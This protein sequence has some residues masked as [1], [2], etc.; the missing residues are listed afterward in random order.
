MSIVSKRFLS[1]LL[2]MFIIFIILF[3]IKQ[4]LPVNNYEIELNNLNELYVEKKIDSEIYLNQFIS[5]THNIDKQN[6]GINLLGFFLIII[7][8]IIIP[9]ITKGQTIGQKLFKLKIKAKNLDI[10][11]LSGRAVIINGLGYLI[12]MFI[13]LF[14][15]TNKIYFILI[16]LLGFFQILVV[17]INAFMVLYYKEGIADKITTTRIEEIKWENLQNKN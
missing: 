12:F 11:D 8:F 15:A 13:I 17:I 2:D 10:K 3:L 4:L 7:S 1:Y 6:F 5:L 16:N 14:I 9:F